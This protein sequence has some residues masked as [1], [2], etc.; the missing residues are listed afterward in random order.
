[1]FGN[2]STSPLNVDPQRPSFFEMV[3]QE[4]V[5]S[6]LKPALRYVLTILSQRHTHLHLALRFLDEGYLVLSALLEYYYLTRHDSTFSENFYGLR[7]SSTRKR[8]LS[9][10]DRAL[11]LASMTLL[12]Y[13]KAKADDAY[14]QY[15]APYYGSMSGAGALGFALSGQQRGRSDPPP[16]LSYQTL[17]RIVSYIYPALHGAYEGSFFVYQL[18]Y[19][20]ELTGFYTP[21]L[22]ATKIQIRR[23]SL[24]EMMAEQKVTL[25]A[26]R[27]ALRSVRGSHLFSQL[28]RLVLL[29]T[30]AA[31]EASGLLLPLTIFSF[32]VLEWW[33]NTDAKDV[34]TQSLPIPPPPEPPTPVPGALAPAATKNTCAICRNSLT[35]PAMSSSGFV[36]CFPCLF[37]HVET[38]GRC[39]ITLKPMGV[40]NIRKVYEAT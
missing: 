25:D 3:Y 31:E 13:V 18:L 16:N 7:R 1:M 36:F 20:Y 35:N 37:A 33:Y 4:R 38:E 9:S 26:R 23:L 34:H 29:M 5:T 39:P 40:D 8:P 32:R 21:V 24:Q 14:N 15:V 28:H 19:L 17:R 30:F 11:S 2:F 27:H 6:G 10:M 22:H 12:P